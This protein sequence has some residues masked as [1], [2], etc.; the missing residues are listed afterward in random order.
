MLASIRCIPFRIA[1]Y[2]HLGYEGA[3]HPTHSSRR[4]VKVSHTRVLFMTELNP[5]N[6][7]ELTLLGLAH[8]LPR[9]ERGGSEHDLKILARRRCNASDH[10]VLAFP[11]ACRGC[12]RPP[13]TV[14]QTAQIRCKRSK[15]KPNSA[16]FCRW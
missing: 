3:A 7:R 10:H 5:K 1:P 12:R 8:N 2:V 14:E 6:P 15:R 16:S 13:M 4:D 9:R 11:T